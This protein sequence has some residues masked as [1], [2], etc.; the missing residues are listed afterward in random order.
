[1][2]NRNYACR[3]CGKMRRAAASGFPDSPAPPEC[4][5]EAMQVLWHEQTVAATQLSDAERVEWLR[6][7][8]QV[9]HRGG[10]RPWKKSS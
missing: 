7:G 2:N 3:R 8:G 10:K 9:V 5:G 1:M 6:D 4:C